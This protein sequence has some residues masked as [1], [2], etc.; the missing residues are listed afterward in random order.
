MGTATRWHGAR[1]WLPLAAL[2][3]LLGGLLHFLGLAD[4]HPDAGR[5][6]FRWIYMQWLESDGDF[7]HAW[8]MPLISLWFVWMRRRDIALAPRR[9][10]G[11]GVALSLLCVVAL[12]VTIRAQQPR[13]T[14]LVFAMLLWVIPYALFG[15]PVARLLAFPVLYVG[16]CF[17]AFYLL[18]VTF[19][20]RLM[21]S[22]ISG[23]LLNGIGIA[24][25]RVGT[26][27]YSTAGGGFQFDVAD[28][29]S[30][31]RSLV[32]ITALCAPYAVLS[33]PRLSGKWLLFLCSIPFAVIANISRILILALL[34]I[35]VS[36]DLALRFYHDFAGYLVFGIAVLLTAVTGYY[37]K[38]LLP[39][40]VPGSGGLSGRG[41][42]GVVDNGGP[43]EAAGEWRRRAVC[44]AGMALVLA[45]ALVVIG[46]DRPA[47]LEEL[48]A[49]ELP[50]ALPGYTGDA[51]R[52]CQNDQCM[53]AFLASRI[54]PAA[55]C[56]RCGGSDLRDVS[57]AERTMLPGDVE[58]VKRHYDGGSR[59]FDV[60]IVRSGISRSGIHRPEVC[61]VAQGFRI[62]DERIVTA[63]SGGRSFAFS[64]L[65]AMNDAGL[66]LYYAYWFRSGDFE[67]AK[68][69]SRLFRTAW[70][71]VTR[72]LRRRWSYVAVTMRMDPAIGEERNLA[73]LDAFLAALHAHLAGDSINT[74]RK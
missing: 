47:V 14:L 7:T 2:L 51:L 35:L 74:A 41:C 29:C 38:R 36:Q 15:F 50:E 31:L 10:Q 28:P 66:S 27:L 22:I 37:L 65:R 34:A 43:C 44:A 21:V 59:A 46:A 57:L 13:L 4:V 30:G 67:T 3:A 62:V 70:D 68:H 20:L 8:L 73:A 52:F 23:A 49:V 25:E 5:S 72:N 33:Q 19:K 48:A 63:E 54:G 58:I 11:W 18:V 56:P 64:R 60:S 55:V 71:G 26:A 12:W 69:S 1:E 6:A 45:A 32:V 53:A 39:G 16:L 17:G 61:L 9:A 42:S 24:T 40:E